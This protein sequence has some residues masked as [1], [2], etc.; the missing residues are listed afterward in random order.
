MRKRISLVAKIGAGLLLT[1]LLVFASFLAY[2][3][4]ADL[5][6]RLTLVESLASRAI[7]REVKIDG[8]LTLDLGRTVEI[9]AGRVRLG[10]APWSPE[11]SMLD[12]RDI[13]L[14]IETRSL[15]SGP[16]RFSR[17][18]IPQAT[19][20]VHRDAD[21]GLNWVLTPETRKEEVAKP[22]RGEPGLPVV[23]DH[24][25]AQQVSMLFRGPN[26]KTDVPMIIG[27]FS[28]IESELGNLDVTAS[29]MLSNK[30]WNLEGDLGSV[31][32]LVSGKHIQTAL[33]VN[34]SFSQLSLNASAENLADLENVEVGLEFDGQD[35]RQITESLGLPQIAHGEFHLKSLIKASADQVQATLDA[36]AGELFA[37]IDLTASELNSDEPLMDAEVRA[38][39]PNLGAIASLLGLPGLEQKPF[40]LSGKFYREAGNTLFDD[41]V[42]EAPNTQISLSGKLTRPPDYLGTR[43]DFRANLPNAESLSRKMGLEWLT[44]GAVVLSASLERSDRGLSLRRAELNLGSTRLVSSGT[45]GNLANLDGTQLTLELESPSAK[46]L[47]ELLNQPDWPVLPIDAQAELEISS[48]QWSLSKLSTRLGEAT[49]TAMGYLGSGPEIIQADLELTVD[50][51]DMEPLGASLGLPAMPKL[52]AH[53]S[54]RMKLAGQKIQLDS[55]A[56]DLGILSLAGTVGVELNPETGNKIDS[57]LTAKGPNFRNAASHAGLDQAPELP[58]KASARVYADPQGLRLEDLDMELGSTRIRGQAEYFP[59]L[60]GSHAVLQAEG[61]DA[62]NL[63]PI[64]QQRALQPL[65]FTLAAELTRDS[66][67]IRIHGARG[68]IAGLSLESSGTLGDWPELDGSN[69]GFSLRSEDLA[70]SVKNWSQAAAP[71]TAFELKGQVSKTGGDVILKADSRVGDDSLSLEGRFSSGT[72]RKFKIKASGTEL[73]LN[74]LEEL[75]PTTARPASSKPDKNTRIVPDLKFPTTWPDYLAGMATLDLDS[76]HH[77]EREFRNIHVEAKLDPQALEIPVA[78]A[79]LGDGTLS[80]TLSARPVESGVHAETTIS[81]RDVKVAAAPASAGVT[82]RPPVDMDIQLSGRGAG[83]R[84]LAGNLDGNIVL[85]HGKGQI[86][87]SVIT[88]DFLAELARLLNPLRQADA[89]T[90]LQ[91]G[92]VILNV[93]EGLVTTDIAMDQT[94]RLLITALATANLKDEKIE[95]LFTIMNREGIGVSAT[96]IVNP[97]VKITG[98]LAKPTLSF[99]PTRAAI[100]YGAAVASGGLSVLAKGVWDRLASS[101]QQCEKELAKRNMRLPGT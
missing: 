41:I 43:L 52:P 64:L 67:G 38:N 84:E 56:L 35:L 34:F 16:L 97:Y 94:N 33:Q 72:P 29:G 75:W 44:P 98:T 26:L 40:S 55:V 39:G 66:H 92:L 31:A 53:G 74:R 51:P 101:G 9:V 83:L 81:G 30:P 60:S 50:L 25:D 19:I 23:V 80:A 71:S 20:I 49:V 1:L 69:L 12:M 54:A 11:P 22:G 42:L 14:V 4:F 86:I 5:G 32:S 93:K 100:S 6:N 18:V 10:N 27:Q 77:G 95:V 46:Q 73:N 8:P 59:G 13:H 87:S 17:I 70:A 28:I 37:D 85:S 2:L 82:A 24:L 91:C 89:P 90:I 63:L 57:T 45:V 3:E 65:P 96:S 99:A 7:G 58:W 68:N 47:G 61:P 36:K 48:G 79:T 88:S 21:R 76:L 78:R 15:F 62:R